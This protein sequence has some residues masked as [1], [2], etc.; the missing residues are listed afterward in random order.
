MKQKILLSV[1]MMAMVLV[2]T[3][4]SKEQSDEEKAMN[5]MAGTWEM[6]IDGGV[7]TIVLTE[8]GWYSCVSVKDESGIEMEPPIP[9]SQGEYWVEGK[10]V[11]DGLYIHLM[12]NGKELRKIV[13]LTYPNQQQTVQLQISG[14]GKK[15]FYAT[16]IR[17]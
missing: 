6:Q 13:I 8:D 5:N 7:T 14:Y 4:C 12:Q 9:D 10:N 15:N 2:A 1:M 11:F 17:F 3:S 16:R